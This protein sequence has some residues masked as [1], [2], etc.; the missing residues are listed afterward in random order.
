MKSF[1]LLNFCQFWLK[2]DY[3]NIYKKLPKSR[4]LLFF[5]FRERAESL[6]GWER[7]CEQGVQRQHAKRGC[8]QGREAAACENGCEQGGEL[9]ACKKGW[10]KMEYFS[11]KGCERGI[12]FKKGSVNRGLGTKWAR[13]DFQIFKKKKQYQG[14]SNK[15]T[16]KL[17][18]APPAP[19]KKNVRGTFFFLKFF[20]FLF[21]LPASKYTDKYIPAAERFF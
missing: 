14:T 10:L 3:I 1:C 5:F 7:G 11:K 13:E 9:A 18:F 12:F 16:S 4:S 6:F 2:F 20:Y 15:M 21:F 17:S 8:E 19:K